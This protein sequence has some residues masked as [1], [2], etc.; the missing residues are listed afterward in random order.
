MVNLD[1]KHRSI[2]P[3]KDGR[4]TVPTLIPGATLRLLGQVPGRGIINMDRT[5][6]V[7]AG[8]TLDLKDLPIPP[9]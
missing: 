7:E 9:P 6:T 1:Y 4:V 3:D 8:R 2:Q 5:F